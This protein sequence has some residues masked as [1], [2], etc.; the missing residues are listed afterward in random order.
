[1]RLMSRTED[2]T[3]FQSVY[4][5]SK[6]AV[7]ILIHCPFV[8]DA[9]HM[10]TL[11]NRYSGCILDVPKEAVLCDENQSIPKD[12]RERVVC[13][14]LLWG[15]HANRGQTTQDIRKV[16]TGSKRILSE[17]FCGCREFVNRHFDLRDGVILKIEKSSLFYPSVFKNCDKGAEIICERTSD[18][19]LGLDVPIEI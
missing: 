8:S 19:T 3:F 10:V 1:M 15:S 17:E 6:I 16:E 11:G 12:V 13:M 5:P 18:R 4:F 9:N 7:V 14:F 2:F